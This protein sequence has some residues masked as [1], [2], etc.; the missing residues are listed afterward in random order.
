M[1]K[2]KLKSHEQTRP[3]PSPSSML[4]LLWSR[5][6]R[7]PTLALRSSTFPGPGPLPWA[8]FVTYENPAI[9]SVTLFLHSV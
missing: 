7:L 6:A 3:E 9:L 8:Q 5:P 1:G 4:C 2:L